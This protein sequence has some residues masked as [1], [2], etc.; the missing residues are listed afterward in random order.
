MYKAD[1]NPQMYKPG[2]NTE[3]WNECEFPKI[4]NKKIGTA[5]VY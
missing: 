3:M 1:D 4:R 2:N 5:T